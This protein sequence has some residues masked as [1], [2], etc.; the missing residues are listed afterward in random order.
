MPESVRRALQ[1]HYAPY[2]ARLEVLLGEPL[3]WS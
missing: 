1:E 3:R 2:N